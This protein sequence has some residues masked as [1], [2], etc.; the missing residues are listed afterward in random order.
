MKSCFLGTKYREL[1]IVRQVQN[2]YNIYALSRHD[3]LGSSFSL[4]SEI[5]TLLPMLKKVK[6]PSPRRIEILGTNSDCL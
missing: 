3:R 1:P 4:S 5:L 2:G 6:G